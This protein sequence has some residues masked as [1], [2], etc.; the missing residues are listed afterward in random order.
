MAV[1]GS[2]PKQYIGRID[3][4][5]SGM[6]KIIMHPGYGFWMYIMHHYSHAYIITVAS[7]PVD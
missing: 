6:L 7:Q 5:G 3:P 4:I 2:V 1:Y